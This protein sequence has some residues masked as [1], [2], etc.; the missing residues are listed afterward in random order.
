MNRHG[1]GV[2]LNDRGQSLVDAVYKALG[3]RHGETGCWV[4]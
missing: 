3:F 4:R 2:G 1:G